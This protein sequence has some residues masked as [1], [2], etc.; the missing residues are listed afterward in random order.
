[1]HQPRCCCGYGSMN[2]N[3]EAPSNIGALRCPVVPNKKKLQ[4]CYLH[5]LRFL[6][7]SFTK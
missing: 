7:F 5:S 1:M 6:S 3:E 4:Q 2:A